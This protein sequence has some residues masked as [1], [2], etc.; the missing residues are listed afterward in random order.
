MGFWFKAF[1]KSCFWKSSEDG[2]WGGR[3]FK[4]KKSCDDRDTYDH[5]KSWFE[6]LKDKAEN[7]ESDNDRSDLKCKPFQKF[8]CDDR[9]NDPGHSFLDKIAYGGH[10]FK[11]GHGSK[12][13]NAGWCA[14]KNRAPE[15]VG[16][17]QKKVKIGPDKSKKDAVIAKI[18][19]TDPDGDTLIFKLG[20]EDADQFEIDETTGEIRNGVDG[21][22]PFDS[23][24]GDSIYELTVT[25]E[26]G[27]GGVS[28]E[29][30]LDT[31]LFAV[32]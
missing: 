15:F 25:V 5:R 9:D 21:L 17:K 20:G 19:A 12:D 10:S 1:K 3:S 2:G 16:E 4:S 18:E 13:D 32:G 27:R 6:R 24:D 31:I 7:Q 26:D 23:A 8:G 11:F 14:P 29:V 30:E 22:K 28:E